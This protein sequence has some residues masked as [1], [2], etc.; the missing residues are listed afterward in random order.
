VIPRDR[1]VQRLRQVLLN[2]TIRWRATYVLLSLREEQVAR[3]VA[4]A[5]APLR[6]SAA[7]ILALEGRP[8]AS[9]KEALEVL[10]REIGGRDWAPILGRMS[11]AREH[12]IL[13]AGIAPATLLAAIDLAEALRVRT[14]TL[15]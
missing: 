7:A 15:R 1:I 3:E 2:A 9:P 14:E 6:S 13:P 12:G 4:E 5:A 11:E 8:A 10:A